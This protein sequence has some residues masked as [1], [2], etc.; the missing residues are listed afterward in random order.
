MPEAKPVRR[1][2]PFVSVEDVRQGALPESSRLVAGSEGMGREV[3]WCAVLRARAPAFDPLRGGELVLLDPTVIPVVDPRLTLPR[4]IESLHGAGIAGIVVAGP[5]ADDSR[6][7]AEALA[8]PLFEVLDPAAPGL[9]ELEQQVL[10]YIVDRRAEL[11]ERT[12][13]LHR[14]LS[15]L[16]LAGRGLRAVLDRLTELAGVP[17]IF[18][19][20]TA[21]DYISAGR[22][23]KLPL[24]V[25][26]AVVQQRHALAAWLRDVPL[27]AFDPPVTDRP[28]PGGRTRLVAPILVQ[29]AIAGFVSLVGGA[30]QLGEVHR[31]AVGRASHACAIEMVRDR[32]AK[33]AKDELEEDV[34]DILTG[35]R[36]GSPAA[37]AER[38]RRRGIEL[39]ARYL[40]AAGQAGESGVSRLKAAWEKQ[41][42]G[43]RLPALVRERDSS[44]LAIVSLAGRRPPE[45]AV[46]LRELQ[47]AGRSACGQ[48]AIGHGTV[49]SGAG[50]VAAAA[51]EA[52]QA[53][54]MGTRLY[55]HDRIVAFQD[56]G[57][58]RLLYSLQRQPELRA[59]TEEALARLGARDR[60]GDLRRTLAAYLECNGS[61]TDAA[62][63]LK[64]HRNTVLY[65]LSRIEELL[66]VDLRE[67]EARL[68]LHL[69]LRIQD[70][71]EP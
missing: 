5:A 64:L 21:I 33:E 7:V 13:D 48:V 58:Y 50:E 38:L 40:V 23:R 26:A 15:E 37:A 45:P 68:T 71:L 3:A 1:S 63:R 46:L 67:A 51:R 24:E 69:A 11:H 54:A 14:Q 18:E 9:D 20:G 30:G 35:G 19:H 52:E 10:R 2:T 17:V 44:A 56:L 8:L 65:R 59:F 70:V 16:A 43:M 47:Q 29:G 32:A 12:A 25:E 61:P 36:P 4:L 42:S 60:N 49:R 28:L 62:L 39:D 53:L 31:L 27:S 34:V 22:D 57:L 41:L 55:G 6:R 66:G